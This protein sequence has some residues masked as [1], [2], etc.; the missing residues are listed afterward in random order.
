MKYEFYINNHNYQKGGIEDYV[1]SLKEIFKRNNLV[2]NVVDKISSDVDVLFVIE[3]FLD[4]PKEI[5]DFLEDS[6]SKSVR[7]C[8]IHS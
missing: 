2:L 3:N 8:L 4:N 7:L 1:H 6:K 5:L